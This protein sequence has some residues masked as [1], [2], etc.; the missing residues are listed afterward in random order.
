[1]GTSFR[2]RPRPE[3]Q[4]AQTGRAIHRARPTS[5]PSSSP[6]SWPRS[7]ANGP[8]SKPNL[9]SALREGKGSSRGP[10]ASSPPF[11]RSSRTITVLDPACGSGNFLYVSLQMLLD[12]EKE[13]ITFATQLGFTLHAG[14]QR[15]PTPRHRDQ[16]LRLRAGPGRPCKSATCNGGATTVSTT[17]A[18][19]CCKTSTASKTK[20]RCSCRTS[21]ARPR[22]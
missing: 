2:P 12:L 9:A 5:S 1:M 4:R 13:V 18:R 14:S 11:S 20:T 22:R 21:T 8:R 19:P 15:A 16:S 6:C 17:T 3:S 10:R 7:A